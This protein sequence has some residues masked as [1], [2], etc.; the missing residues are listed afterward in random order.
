MTP[1]SILD[2]EARRRKIL[3]AALSGLKPVSTDTSVP[4]NAPTKR[5]VQLDPDLP[6]DMPDRDFTSVPKPEK[7]PVIR[8]GYGAKGLTSVDRLMAQR[9]TLRDFPNSRVRENSPG[10][11]EALPPGVNEKGQLKKPS[12]IK[13][14]LKGIVIGTAEAA[15]QSGNDLGAEIG[16]AAAGGAIGAIKPDTWNAMKRAGEIQQV[17]QEITQGL[18]QRKLQAEA[19]RAERDPIHPPQYLTREDEQGNTIRQQVNPQT[20][21][22]EDMIGPDGQPV[23]VKRPPPQ[24]VV[25][26]RA[27]ILRTRKNRDGTETTLKSTDNGETWQEINDLTSTSPEK[28]DNSEFTNETLNAAIKEAQDERNLIDERLKTTPKTVPTDT[29]GVM[30]PNP[31]Y[32]QLEERSRKLHSDILDWKTKMKAPTLAPKSSGLTIEGAI[33][34][35]KKTK[36]RAPTEQEIANMKAALSQ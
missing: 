1:A 13:E 34:H 21:Q 8:V 3:E 33:E 17:N 14:L 9:D 32:H 25:Q 19:D 35:F 15:R 26:P 11:F 6:N 7:T 36:K 30:A 5:P 24:K 23:I 2:P 10:E 20:Q 31:E 29:Q 12:R 18:Q 16:G 22:P 28:A 4:G 27:P